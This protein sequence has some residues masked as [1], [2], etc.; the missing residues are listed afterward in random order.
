[1]TTI[2]SPGSDEND[3]DSDLALVE[4]AIEGS[5]DALRSLV[6]RHQPF[7][8]NLALKMFGDADDA[9]DL[10]QEVFIK[11]ITAL[12][13]FRRESRFRTWLHRIAVNHFLKTRRRGRERA[14]SDF[15]AYFDAIA[16]VPDEEPPAGEIAGRTVEE[17]RLRCTTGMLMCLDREQRLVFVLGEIF[18]VT[19]VVGSAILEVGRDA[20]RQ[21]LARAR[22]QLASFMRDQCGLVDPRNPCRCAAK[23]RAFVRDG[24]VDPRR[25]VFHAPHVARVREVCAQRRPA[26]DALID[27]AYARL[28]RDQ[29]FYAVPD[30]VARVRALLSGAPLQHTLEVSPP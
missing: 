4:R 8:Y 28:Y 19:D 12:K 20:F 7:V 1:M 11:A 5:R 22:Q 23:T 30:M 2:D 9:D 21:K 15:E 24:I 3:D 29:P 6:E 13:T 27:D 16:A 25:L 10:V 18:E 17:L 26:L 14:A